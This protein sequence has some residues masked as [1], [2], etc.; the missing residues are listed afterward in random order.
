MG[1][2]APEVAGPAAS[3][4]PTAGPLPE[5]TAAPLEAQFDG[6]T[7]LVEPAQPS[8]GTEV[9][10]IAR[11][12]RN[13]RPAPDLPLHA[14][15]HFRTVDE[16]WPAG[17]DTVLTD[18]QGEG[19]IRFNIGKATRGYTVNVAVIADVEGRPLVWPAAFTPR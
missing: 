19:R 18:E 14:L 10:V 9:M 5:P 11:V 6:T 15:V 1:Q 4:G 3:P 13:G 12:V 16:R 2:P 17:A 7:L 8:P